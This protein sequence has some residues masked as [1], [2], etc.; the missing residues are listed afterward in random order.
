MSH[1]TTITTQIKD[2]NIL[3]RA[4]E[5]LG[6]TLVS[7]TVAKATTTSTACD[8]CIQHPDCFNDIAVIAENGYYTLKVYFSESLRK[9]YGNPYTENSQK[10]YKY[11]GRLLQEYAKETIKHTM[12][13]YN[14]M[15]SSEKYEN[16]VIKLTLTSYQ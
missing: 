7:K 16:G 1:F 6:A 8:Y 5:N 15:L 10:E 12:L 4:C 9:I 14:L 11:I 2:L 13:N 3:K